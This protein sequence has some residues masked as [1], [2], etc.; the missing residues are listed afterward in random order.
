MIVKGTLYIALS[1]V[2]FLASSYGIHISMAYLVSTREYGTLGVVLS[3]VTLARVFLSTGI[4]QTA[5]YF[6]AANAESAYGVWRRAAALQVGCSVV[7]AVIYV[8]AASWWTTAVGDASLVKLVLLSAPM[9]VLMAWYQINL[10]Y[11]NGRLL[12]GRQAA[13][14]TLYSVA[15]GAFAITLV[16]LGYEVAG[17]VAGLVVA[18]G[19]VAV[20]SYAWIPRG[21]GDCPVSWRELISFS[22]PLVVVAIGTAVLLNIDILLL[23][24]F[25]P[26]S[27]GVGYY[28]AAMNL[29]KAPYFVFYAVAATA[30]PAL[31]KTFKD[32]GREAALTLA[33]RMVS[34]LVIATLPVAVIVA[35]SSPKLLALV[36]R[37]QYIAGAPALSL[38]IVS[39]CGLVLLVVLNTIITAA[40]SPRL[41]M[42]VVLVGIPLQIG[43]GCLLIPRE[44]TIGAALA[45]LITVG[46]TVVLAGGF[47]LWRVGNVFDVG[48]LGKA[49]VAVAP[50]G[51]SLGYFDDYPAVAVPIVYAGAL[52]VYLALLV[53]LGAMPLAEFR[54]LTAGRR[55]A[56]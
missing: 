43:L 19:V 38:L 40:G 17:A 36:Y 34:Y 3:M 52:L 30:L 2:A 33:R 5:S 39:M 47:V 4:P 50:V 42:A 37:H 8:A 23:Q 35:L 56:S 26:D 48:R 7:V 11:Y 29:G 53:A 18:I 27:D 1:R 21:E 51:M 14:V 12:F 10:A 49:V 54:R 25:F 16:L 24:S 45:N 44:E 9:I 55:G 13:F 31:S 28:N 46:F 20:I 22:V 15:R 6:M 32:K 41:A